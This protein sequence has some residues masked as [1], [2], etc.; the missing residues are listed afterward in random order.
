[1]LEIVPYEGYIGMVGQ[2]MIQT[3]GRMGYGLGASGGGMADD[4][5]TARG[6]VG[7]PRGTSS[8][9]ISNRCRRV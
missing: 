2:K 1:M 8:K 3:N 4:A 5:L 6:E 7:V 9:V